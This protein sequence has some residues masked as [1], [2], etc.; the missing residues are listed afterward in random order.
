MA[1]YIGKGRGLVQVD[2]Y[3]RDEADAATTPT[4]VSDKDNEST[5]YFDVPAGTTAERPSNP[6]YG[7]IR[8]NTSLDQLEQYTSSGWQGIS[9][10]PVITSVDVN[11]IDE[12]DDP[13]TIV[14]IGSNFDTG[15]VGVLVDANGN[16]LTPTTSV[17]NSSAQITI[18]YS[19]GDRITSSDAEPLSVK[20]SAGSGI[21]AILE[22]V[23]SIDATP[24]WSTSVGSLGTVIE[25]VAISTI[26]LSA[27]DPEG[28]TPTYSI[29]SGA[30]PS[31][32]SLS[33]AGSITGTPNVNDSYN[34]SGVT[35]NFTVSASDGTGNSTP[36]AFSILRKWQDGSTAETAGLSAAD[37]ISSTGSSSLPDGL[38]W[39][40]PSGY[41]TAFQIY[42]RMQPVGSSGTGWMMLMNWYG[43]NNV[44][45]RTDA[46]LYSLAPSVQSSNLGKGSNTMRYL[47]LAQR[48]AM[49]NA[50]LNT[51]SLIF[52]RYRNVA[53]TTNDSDNI[54]GWFGPHR[55][56]WGQTNPGHRDVDRNT[57][58]T[59]D[60][61]NVASF[62]NGS[63]ARYHWSNSGM[64]VR[65]VWNTTDGAAI[66]GIRGDGWTTGGSNQ[67]VEIFVK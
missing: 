46:S 32:L 43:S 3:T 18:T 25:D 9:P 48:D 34:S 8:F 54:K 13:Q 64:A 24:I 55:L 23:I 53:F 12:S 39:I 20:V 4:G 47:P 67:W 57:V 66:M 45:F 52:D 56:S 16:T 37:I 51:N 58:I 33:S 7:Y 2:G 11:N 31:G 62:I 65:E 6:N 40:K 30:L 27:T 15:S 1:G 17:R 59:Y 38:Y 60:P 29:T 42:C 28:S 14:V 5:G 21:N 63:D 26:T 19:G 41:S 35:H 36:R 10:P 44:D 61:G 50:G 49:W 22:D